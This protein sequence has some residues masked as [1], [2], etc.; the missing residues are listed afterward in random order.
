MKKCVD[1]II[2]NPI[3]FTSNHRL[4]TNECARIGADVRRRASDGAQKRQQ[5][6]QQSTS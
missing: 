3:S 2:P 5:E 1:V 6:R 4:N